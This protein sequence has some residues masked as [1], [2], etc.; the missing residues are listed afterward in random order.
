MNVATLVERVRSEVLDDEIE[1]YLWTDTNLINYLNDTIDELAEDNLVMTDQSTASVAEIKLL[2]NQILH[3]IDDRVLQVRYGRLETNKTDVI[4]TTEDWLNGNIADWR[5]TDGSAPTYFCPSVS[6]GYLSIYPKYDAT[7]EYLGVANISFVGG[8][9]K[10]ITQLTGDFSGLVAGD[11]IYISGTTDNNGFFT[12]VTAG[13]TSFTVSES[14][15]TEASTSATI[16]KVMDTLLMT[17]NRISMT[18]FTVSDIAD[19]TD[20]T[21][22]KSVHHSKLLNGIAKKAFL[23]PDSDTY[24]KG[25]AEYHRG[26]FEVDKKRMKRDIILLNKP[27]RSRTIRSGTGIGY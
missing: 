15:T 2:S 13:T 16:R 24:D 9:T 21:E 25:K 4:K 18:P 8:A 10:S 5:N 12:V 7:Y 1:P 23:K 22:L 20:I 17:V 6:K 26:L 14:V 27:D 11:E 19:S 3:P